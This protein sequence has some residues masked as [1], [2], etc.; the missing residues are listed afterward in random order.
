M[1]TRK[2]RVMDDKTPSEVDVL[3]DHLPENLPHVETLDKLNQKVQPDF[4]ID[5]EAIIKHDGPNAVQVISLYVHFEGVC[6]LIGY[7]A[8]HREWEHI[9]TFHYL[10]TEYEKVND[11]IETWAKESHESLEFEILPDDA[12]PPA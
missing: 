1:I 7:H 8:D 9:D 11:R 10:T 4:M 6:H 12:E 5:T 2:F 3:I